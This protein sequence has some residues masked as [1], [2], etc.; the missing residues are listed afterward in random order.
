M[1]YILSTFLF[2]ISS[3]LYPDSLRTG[4]VETDQG[5]DFILIRT[6]NYKEVDSWEEDKKLY[7]FPNKF[8]DAEI[9]EVQGRNKDLCYS[10]I[11]SRRHIWYKNEWLGRFK[12]VRFRCEY[13]K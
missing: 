4:S 11:F 8:L 5:W 1:K 7:Q 3:I 9:S 6:F 12:H 13:V 2:F 10:E